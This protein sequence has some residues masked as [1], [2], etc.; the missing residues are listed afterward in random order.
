[1]SD[2]F[3]VASL[4]ELEA[5]GLGWAA[6]GRACCIIPRAA[7]DRRRRASNVEIVMGLIMDV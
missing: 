6:S 7:S 2:A 5:E 3:R 4:D 1:L